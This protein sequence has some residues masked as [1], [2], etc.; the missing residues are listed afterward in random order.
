MPEFPSVREILGMLVEK[1][2]YTPRGQRDIAEEIV[3]FAN[4][5]S[6]GDA[7]L[8]EF[9]PAAKFA[10]K[11]PKPCNVTIDI[12][13]GSDECVVF[14]GHFD[15][16]PPTDYPSDFERNPDQL[17]QDEEHHDICYGLGSYDMLAGC[18][19]YLAAAR[20]L[21]VATHRRIRILLVWGEENQSEG[22]HAALHSS[23]DLLE[24][25]S[26]AIS[27]EVPVGAELGDHANL[28]IGRPGRVG[29]QLRVQG[30]T[31]HSG[32]VRREILHTLAPHRDAMVTLALEQLRFPEHPNDPLHLMPESLCVPDEW[33]SKRP[34]SL[35]V[36]SEGIKNYDV[37]FTH[38]GLDPT[39]IHSIVHR[40]VRGA[41]GDDNFTL[42]LEPDRELPFTK[43][44]LEEPHYTIVR[45]GLRYASEVYNKDATLKAGRGVADEAIVVHSKHIPAISFPPEGTGEHTRNERVRI[46]SVEQRV[47]PFLQKIAA[48]DGL[49]TS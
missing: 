28:Y 33:R 20:D 42:L 25:A 35:T 13:Q 19:A 31:M 16:V 8:V 45:H 40:A 11:S 10:E 30:P 7:R 48:H 12:G 29:L 37:L 36:P 21:Q 41:L 9:P 15:K 27:T 24:G 43:P 22:T 26:C 2:S 4:R 32:R 14:L 18:A 44:W 1:R 47:V 17:I 49:L 46:S 6:L 5:W 23:Q 3:Q 34:H 39:A 38:P